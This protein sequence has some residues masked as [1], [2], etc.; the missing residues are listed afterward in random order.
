MRKGYCLILLFSAFMGIN[1]AF[2]QS[3]NEPEALGLPGDNL[4]LYAVLEVFQKSKTIEDFEKSLNDKEGN[5]NNLDLNNNDETDYISVISEKD[6]DNHSIILQVAVNEKENQDIAVIEVSKNKSGKVVVQIIGDEELYGKDYIV[7]PSNEVVGGTPNPGYTGGDTVIIN[8]NTT[9]N[10]NTTNTTNN[11]SNNNGASYVEPSGWSVVMFLFSPVYVVYRS[12]F[13]W[14]YYPSYWHPWRP[15]YYHS[16]WGYHGHYH[17]HHHYRRT[18]IIINHNHYHNNYYG[19]RKS[20]MI[21]ANNRRDGRYNGIYDGRTYKKPTVPSRP[22]LNIKPSR[23]V[24]K[25]AVRPSKPSTKPEVRPSRPSTTRPVVTPSRPTKP[26]KKPSYKPA[27][28]P[29]NKPVTRPAI[30]PVKKKSVQR[31]TNR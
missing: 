6:G 10:Y 27:S 30:R 29:M 16:Y 8:N 24:T 12:P 5:V 21:V 26:L 14:G 1:F 17:H 4:S 31:S 9:N 2:S 19:R 23:P 7:E 25:P 18:T 22:D 13:Y 28:K 11:T 20:S 15:I 3:N